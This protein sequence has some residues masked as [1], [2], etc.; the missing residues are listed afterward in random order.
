MFDL[1]SLVSKQV[2]ED[3]FLMLKRGV[4]VSKRDFF[5]ILRTAKKQKIKVNDLMNSIVAVAADT[6][7]EQGLYK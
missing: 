2:D 6:F 1:K 7:R 3:D 4:V 5:T